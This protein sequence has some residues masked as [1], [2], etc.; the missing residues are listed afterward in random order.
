MEGTYTED[1]LKEWPYWCMIRRGGHGSKVKNW[2][3]MW[4]VQPGLIRVALGTA[5]LIICASRMIQ[6]QALGAPCI[7]WNP[8]ISHTCQDEMY[9]TCHRTGLT[10]ASYVFEHRP[11]PEKH[12]IGEIRAFGAKAL[13]VEARLGIPKWHTLSL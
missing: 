12:R 1:C 8:F 7:H 6:V 9:S 2:L 3:R 10:V 4:K 11:C 5:C 13:Q